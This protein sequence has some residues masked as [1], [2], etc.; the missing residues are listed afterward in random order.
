MSLKE[1]FATQQ[2]K[3]IFQ[4]L[5]GLQALKT[6]PNKKALKEQPPNIIVAGSKEDLPPPQEYYPSNE[7]MKSNYN[8]YVVFVDSTTNEL[9]KDDIDYLTNYIKFIVPA[10]EDPEDYQFGEF[11]FAHFFGA[12]F[13]CTF[14]YNTNKSNTHYHPEI[15]K[16]FEGMCLNFAIGDINE[17]S[18]SRIIQK[19]I[20][21]K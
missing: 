19:T 6:V 14:F 3:I 2:M 18:V 7:N 15:E 8:I 20:T 21:A 17:E 13:G 16:E 5:A 4:G 1:R 10:L 9:G 11:E 12:E